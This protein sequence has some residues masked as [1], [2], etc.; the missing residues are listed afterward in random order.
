MKIAS[1][2][3]RCADILTFF[4]NLYAIN[5]LEEVSEYINMCLPHM[6]SETHM[7]IVGDASRN[8]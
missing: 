2:C 8:A 3:A 1:M 6:T 7:L 4:V 5:G